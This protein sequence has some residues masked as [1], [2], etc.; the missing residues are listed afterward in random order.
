MSKKIVWL[1]LSFLMVAALVLASCATA[2]TG[3]TEGQTV[4][5]EVTQP[6]TPDAPEEAVTEEQVVAP[7]GPQYGGTIVDMLASEPTQTDPWY[8]PEVP[9]AQAVA[10]VL[11]TLGIVDWLKRDEVD[12]V[13]PYCPITLAKGNLAESWEEPDALTIIF[14]IRQGV[15]WHNKPP[16]NGRELTAYDIE[17]HWHRLLGLG[18][19]FTEPSPLPTLAKGPIESITATDKWTLVVE[20]SEP[21]IGVLPRLLFDSLQGFIVPPEVIQEYGDVRDWRNL[22][23]TGPYELTDWVSGSSITYTKNPNYW[24]YDER[25]PENLLPY[26]DEI[27]VMIMPDSSTQLSALRSG[28]LDRLMRLGIQDAESLWSTNPELISQSKPGVVSYGCWAMSASKPPF[29]DIRVR[30]AMQLALDNETI[31][32]T[33]FKGTADPTPFG[34]VGEAPHGYY[35]PFEEWPEEIKKYYRYDPE[36]AKRLLAEAGYP[37]GFDTFLEIPAWT[38]VDQAQI[39]VAYWADIGVDVTIEVIET[40]VF[41]ARAAERTI[42][43]LTWGQMATNYSPIHLLQSLAYSTATENLH[44]VSDPEMDRLI[45]VAEAATT[46]EEHMRLVAEADFYF[47]S[48]NWVVWGGKSG[49]IHFW[50]PWLK[51]HT[52]AHSMGGGTSILTLSRVWID[53]ELKESMGH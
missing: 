12:H 29:D 53:Q 39:N 41:Y 3:P 47:I 15:H 31:A 22:V 52:A 6:T 45:D 16:V 46:R 38:D 18:S 10:L 9:T 11:E 1:L 42:K 13:S 14:N 35:I 25:H 24:G 23:G 7:T 37:D 30:R 44:G 28:K 50:Q 51:G 19:G 2:E 27:R 20:L 33:Y 26:A 48:Q 17:Y 4:T 21:N 43:G 32:Q 34:I 40:A 5:G 36:E 8:G 49:S